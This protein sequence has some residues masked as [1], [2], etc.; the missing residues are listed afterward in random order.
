MGVKKFL[1]IVVA[2]L[3]AVALVVPAAVIG[4]PEALATR[5]LPA[6]VDPGADFDV[7]IE[8]SGCGNFGQVVETLPN[9]FSYV[10]TDSTDVI[11]T[12]EDSTVK[13]TFMG[14]A[15]S[16]DY[17][18]TASTTAGTYSFSGVVKDEDKI[19]YTIGGDT[20]IWLFDGGWFIELGVSPEGSG[21][22]KVNGAI[23]ESFPGWSEVF[24]W[25]SEVE[26]EAVPA[27][28]YIFVEW[29]GDASG[30]E[31]P[32][33]MIDGVQKEVTTTSKVANLMVVTVHATFE[34][35]AQASAT[36]TLPI[37]IFDS[38]VNAGANFDVTIAASGCGAFGQVVET[39]PNGFSYV[40]CASTEISITATDSTIKF[41]FVGDSV[42]FTYTAKA[43]TTPGVYTFSGIV[44]DEYKVEYPIG[45]VEN[46][47]VPWY[48]A[49]DED[50]AISKAEAVTAVVEYFD[51]DITKEHALEVIA[52]Y[53]AS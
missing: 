39:L 43:S 2:A 33:I 19:E 1:P 23:P 11:V 48:Y 5:T 35:A 45:G 52:C 25:G 47:C 37:S 21:V 44:K 34:V 17:T 26:L 28:G 32:I 42:T 6:S 3:L 53:F 4:A 49:A 20:T 16:F 29:S 12:P 36:R 41:T 8:A 40:S 46:I 10:G 51:G 27:E 9:G 38:V 22:I 15:V 14:D 30:T 13:F 50:C 7:G 24:D 18:V 31:N